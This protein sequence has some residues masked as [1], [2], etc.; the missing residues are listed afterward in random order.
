MTDHNLIYLTPTALQEH[1]QAALDDDPCD[2]V[3]AFVVNADTDTL[4]VIGSEACWDEGLW[5][6]YD[7]AVRSA[8]EYYKKQQQQENN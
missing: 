4:N 5:E 3:A 7:R 8:A 2:D 6:A 1:F